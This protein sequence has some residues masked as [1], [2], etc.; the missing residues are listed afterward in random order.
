MTCICAPIDEAEAATLTRQGPPAD[1]FEDAAADERRRS[2]R[3]KE[4]L[5]GRR[6]VDAI[7]LAVLG[8]NVAVVRELD[9]AL[10]EKPDAERADDDASRLEGD[11]SLRLKRSRVSDELSGGT[12]GDVTGDWTTDAPLVLAGALSGS[13]ARTAVMSVARPS[14][15]R[16]L[17]A[18]LAIL[19]A[20]ARDGLVVHDLDD[21]NAQTIADLDLLVVDDAT[22]TT[23]SA[24]CISPIRVRQSRLAALVLRRR[25]RRTRGDG[26]LRRPQA[27]LEREVHFAPVL[28][29][30]EEVAAQLVE[31]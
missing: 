11:C 30:V 3:K 5:A 12:I 15:G 1:R 19:L 28:V 10:R 18:V 8:L 17:C 2:E 13:F 31:R 26:E 25:E 24:P 14:A 27:V 4:R 16:R 6:R 7:A 21:P 23:M 9:E 22:A 29:A 20:L